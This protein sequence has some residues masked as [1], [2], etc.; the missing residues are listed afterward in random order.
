MLET[1][2]LAKH[3]NRDTGVGKFQIWGMLCGTSPKMGED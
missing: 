2:A 3:N 1:S